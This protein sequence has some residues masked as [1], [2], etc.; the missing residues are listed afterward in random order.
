MQF[1]I[2]RWLRSFFALGPYEQVDAGD[3]AMR[4][5]AIGFL[6]AGV[7]VWKGWEKKGRRGTERASF[8]FLE[9]AKRFF[10][11]GGGKDSIFLRC[12]R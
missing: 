2:T 7:E 5:V 8:Q 11:A 3:M 6:A 12:P 1:S 9:R 10:F 4:H